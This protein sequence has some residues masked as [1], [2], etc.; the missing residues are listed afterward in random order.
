MSITIDPVPD[1]PIAVGDS[2]GVIQDTTQ[3][4]AVQANDSDVDSAILTLTGYTNP[5]HGTLITAG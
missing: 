5:S 2:I 3:F 4:L 1:V